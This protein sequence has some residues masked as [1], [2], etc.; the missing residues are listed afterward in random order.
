MS[1]QSLATISTAVQR[2]GD[3]AQIALEKRVLR[4]S[5]NGLSAK[6][7]AKVNGKWI[8]TE[9]YA[10]SDEL[11]MALYIAQKSSGLMAARGELYAIPNVG[12][13]VAAKVRAYDAVMAASKRGDT[14]SLS[15][16]TLAPSNPKWKEY[17]AEYKLQPADTVRIVQA[18]SSKHR[19]EWYNNRLAYIN[20]LKALGYARPDIEAR[21]L[22]SF[23]RG[24]P[25]MEAI[26]IVK[27]NENLGDTDYDSGQIDPKKA[28][29]N[30]R[31]D[32]ADKRALSRWISKFGYA[33]PDTR[34]YGV[35]L[36]TDAD[37][38]LAASKTRAGAIEG[39]YRFVD[40][41]ITPGVNIAG[42]EWGNEPP[43]TEASSTATSA[44]KLGRDGD[45][46]ESL[47]PTGLQ[48]VEQAKPITIALRKSIDAMAEQYANENRNATDNQRTMA[49]VL[50]Q[51]T[52]GQDDAKRHTVQ[53]ALT[54]FESW[55]EIPSPYVLALI[56]W[57]KPTQNGDKKYHPDPAAIQDVEA[58]VKEALI[59]AG[60]QPLI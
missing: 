54:G 53:H 7:R 4:A 3:D 19:Q 16:Y 59:A 31:S 41:P 29:L 52:C 45:S 22:E 20:E 49:F 46:T 37:T 35:S 15:F 21:L 27:A 44:Q 13:T 1:E 8:E 25:P 23:G 14:L 36:A 57:M 30:S 10:V 11:V 28:A 55:K 60:Q 38:D 33:A 5:V 26:G 12:I 2:Y 39:E 50:L 51:E 56:K 58:I 6:K 18:I 47:V 43:A 17:E 9:E 48:A 24:C 42:P 32:R 34:N 40:T